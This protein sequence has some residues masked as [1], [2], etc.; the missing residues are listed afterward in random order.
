MTITN[1]ARRS[2]LL[3]AVVA[4]LVALIPAPSASAHTP[5][6]AV[7]VGEA[8]LN[9][10]FGACWASGSF[11]GTAVAGINGTDV[12]VNGSASATFEY[13]NTQVT[14][15]VRNASITIAGHTC[16]FTWVRAGVVAV[17]TFTG[18]CNG[19]GVA[20]FAPTGTNTAQ[21]VGVGGIV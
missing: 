2:L 12:I 13:C 5:V 15:E 17:I 11:S 9:G 6:E 1:L 18:G 16:G 19:G 10:G 21:V 20:A 8:R 4:M 7:V 14:G 3:S